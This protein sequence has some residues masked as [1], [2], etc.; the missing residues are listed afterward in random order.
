MDNELKHYGVP[1]MRW[2]HRKASGIVASKPKGDRGNWG[3]DPMS[4]RKQKWID[5]NGINPNRPYGTKSGLNVKSRSH[6]KQISKGKK[7]AGG[8]LVGL[9]TASVAAI[10]VTAATRAVVKKAMGQIWE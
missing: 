8:I 7:V 6:N 9:G 1:G 2:G 3:R 4:K 5:D 10:A